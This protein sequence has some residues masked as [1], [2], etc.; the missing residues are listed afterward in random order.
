[1]SKFARKIL[2]AGSSGAKGA[3]REANAKRRAGPDSRGELADGATP[4]RKERDT[5]PGRR[6]IHAFRMHNLFARRLTRREGNPSEENRTCL[7]L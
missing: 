7:L 2:Q 6:G 3:D 1:M 4:D 5:N